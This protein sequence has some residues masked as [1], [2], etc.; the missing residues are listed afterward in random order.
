MTAPVREV[1]D[2]YFGQ[3]LI[4]PYRWMEKENDPELAAYL[5]SQNEHARSLLARIPGRAE[6]LHE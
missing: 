3:T 6:L 2:R 1:E 4:D 5:R